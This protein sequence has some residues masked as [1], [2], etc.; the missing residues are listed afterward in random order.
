MHTIKLMIFIT[1]AAL[2]SKNN[3]FCDK[4]P[5]PFPITQDYRMLMLRVRIKFGN[6]HHDLNEAPRCKLSTHRVLASF[7]N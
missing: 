1:V 7:V 5:Y 2:F 4:I 6:G 3:T